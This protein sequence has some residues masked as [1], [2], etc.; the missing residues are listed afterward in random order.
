MTAIYS[1]AALGASVGGAVRLV[2]CGLVRPGNQ[3][4]PY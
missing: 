3:R 4:R 1:L 2:R